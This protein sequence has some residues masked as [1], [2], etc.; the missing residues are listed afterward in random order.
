[1]SFVIKKVYF[2]HIQLGYDNHFATCFFENVFP[3]FSWMFL[4]KSSMILQDNQSLNAWH[5]QGQENSDL[6]TLSGKTISEFQE[7][8]SDWFSEIVK[9]Y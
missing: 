9:L 2:N 3:V 6:L 1:M 8:K 4:S 5:H 7:L